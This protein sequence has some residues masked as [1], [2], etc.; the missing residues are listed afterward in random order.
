MTV[1][2]AADRIV[3][4]GPTGAG[5]TTLAVALQEKTGHPL[6]ELDALNLNPDWT[7]ADL[8][9]YRSRVLRA[10][11]QEKWIVVGHYPQSRD[12][13]WPQADLIVWLDYPLRIVLR[14]LARRQGR[15][16]VRKEELCTGR[17]SRGWEQFAPHTFVKV[18]FE[19]L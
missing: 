19:R 8:E 17:K 1:D 2:R 18:V 16:F 11:D 10:I 3:V 12:L 5:K 7:R 9:T 4:I 15:S 13:V 14:H 6:V